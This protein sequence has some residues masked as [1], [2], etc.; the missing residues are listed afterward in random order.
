MASTDDVTGALRET[1]EAV[2]ATQ[3][4]MGEDVAE[5]ASAVTELTSTAEKLINALASIDELARAV[6]QLGNTVTTYT[7]KLG[8]LY[9][10]QTETAER[11]GRYLQDAAKQQ[12]GIRDVDKRLRVLEGGAVGE[13]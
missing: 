5:M 13:R 2:M 10:A 9:D 8:A 12:S 11:L 1:V 7:G 3:K 6:E 4:A